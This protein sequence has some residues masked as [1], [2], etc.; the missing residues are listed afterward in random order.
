MKLD[1]KKLSKEMSLKDKAKILFA[2]HNKRVET[3]GMERLLTP[4]EEKA[5]VEDART[6]NQV[7]ELN[8]LTELFNL[9]GL[10]LLDVQTAYLQFLLKRSHLEQVITGI[11]ITNEVD[12]TL[13]SL[14]YDLKTLEVSLDGEKEK[15]YL[16]LKNK[17]LNSK[18]Y[19]QYGYFTIDPETKR[20]QPN[21]LLQ[22]AF[23]RLVERVRDFR[24]MIYT[25]NYII[26][27]AEIDFLADEKKKSLT[28]FE[29]EVDDFYNLEGLLNVLRSYRNFAD[30]NLME[31]GNLKEPGFIEAIRDP[32]K[33]SELTDDDKA[34]AEEQVHEILAA[35]GSSY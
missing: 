18:I 15:S 10:I 23:M 7:G 26:Q 24:R 17:Y 32:E 29:T 2:D 4:Q 9:S 12:D 8:R 19:S 30:K 33:A 28:D 27:L 20:R 6:K 13:N 14:F 31:T 11:M 35:Q 34:K 3:A 21:K 16:E 5:I 25:L 1:L 22:I